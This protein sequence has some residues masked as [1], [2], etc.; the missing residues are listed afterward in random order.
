MENLKL[1]VVFVIQP[2]N[3]ISFPNARECFPFS[4]EFSSHL[5][6]N[7]IIF[8]AVS[9]H[10]LERMINHHSTWIQIYNREDDHVRHKRRGGSSPTPPQDIFLL[11]LEFTWT[12]ARKKMII[13]LWMD[14]G[15]LQ[16]MYGAV[17]KGEMIR[18]WINWY[19]E[20]VIIYHTFLPLRWH[21][22]WYLTHLTV[23][24]E[25][26]ASPGWVAVRNRIH[27]IKYI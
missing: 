27:L 17:Q 25:L 7:P 22:W 20:K 5:L 18:T 2:E 24:K 6:L 23:S 10:Y 8:Y 13:R 15:S 21:S 12:H 4:M 19:Y 1:P 16:N 26:M 14:C 9:F 11:I 3:G